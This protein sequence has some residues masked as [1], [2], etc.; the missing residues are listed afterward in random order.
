MH[1]SSGVAN[2]VAPITHHFLDATH[3]S[4]GV[5]TLGVRNRYAQAEASFFN[6]REPDQ[7][8]WRPDRP[9][10]NSFAARLSATPG[11][12][13]ALQASFAQLREPERL[14]PVHDIRRA[15]VS[16]TYHRAFA[17]GHWATTVAWGRNDRPE[18]TLTL[19]EARARLPQPILDHY[20][21]T[22]SLPPDADATLLL[23]LPKRSQ[24][25]VLVESSIAVHGTTVF[26]RYERVSKDELIRLPDPR[27]S[28][29]YPVGKLD[30]GF[31]QDLPLF[32]IPTLS[33]GGSASLHFVD[34]DLASV[35]G[36]S[37]RSFMVFA[38]ARM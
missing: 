14:H 37:P 11:P 29:T 4:H 28:T 19:G 35:Y 27:H 21:G 25:A 33:V 34:G 9:G 10:L 3:T 12:G 26:T 24:A 15:T 30:I 36:S 7:N 2:P 17:A 1:R 18:T 23:L 6:A 8:R 16:A 5:V 22:A 31:A 20:L 32:S 13:W 38:R